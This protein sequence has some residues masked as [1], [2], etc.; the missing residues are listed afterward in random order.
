VGI[1]GVVAVAAAVF[2]VSA[3]YAPAAIR[4]PPSAQFQ[5]ALDDWA[6]THRSFPGV[7]LAVVGRNGAW[8][9]AA[10]S[11]A[12][13]S[14]QPLSPQSP[15]RTASVTKT[16]TAASVL[17]LVEQGKVG[18]DD[19][20]GKHLSAASRRLLEADGYDLGAI[21]VRLL[22]QHRSGIYDYAEDQAFQQFVITHPRHRWSRQEQ[23]RWAM[24]HGDPV[25]APGTSFGYSDTGY[26]LLGELLERTSGRTLASA[27]RSLLAFDKL[28]LDHTYLESAEPKPPHLQQR[29]HQY[30]AQYDLTNHDPSFDVYGGGGLVSTTGDLVRFFQALVGGQILQPATLKAM[31]TVPTGSD[32]G[33]GI[34]AFQV[35]GERCF[36]HDGFW[37]ITVMHCP[38]SGVTIASAVDQRV[39]FEQAVAPLHAKILRLAHH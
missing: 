18:L 5:R 38:G 27:Y 17:R 20:I 34:F 15:F 16:F 37:G 33:M 13:H 9:G 23:L 1:V 22:L 19:P 4:R 39:G 30:F 8:A 25:F 14:R 21:T 12:M 36:G 28:G 10:G 35:G 24:T 6:R 32:A 29:A 2:V 3:S 7:L 11:M 31:L 26:I